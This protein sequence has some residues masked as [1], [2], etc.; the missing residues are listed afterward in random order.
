MNLCFVGYL[1][2]LLEGGLIPLVYGELN[3]KKKAELWPLCEAWPHEL[4]HKDLNMQTWINRHNRFCCDWHHPPP[5]T[6]SASSNGAEYMSI[7]L[8]FERSWIMG[9][10]IDRRSAIV[11]CKTSYVQ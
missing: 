8:C 9:F 5:I 6:L 10:D 1:L 11:V 2:K 4:N 7:P 3:Q